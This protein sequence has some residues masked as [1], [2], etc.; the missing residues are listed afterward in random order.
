MMTTRTPSAA[1]DPE[2]NS[3]FVV[4]PL[5]A[6]I[7]ATAVLMALAVLLA[8]ASVEIGT[9]NVTDAMI[10]AVGLIVAGPA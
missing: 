10:W 5:L 3:L 6:G 4:W 7:G 2:S 8:A 9:H 1:V